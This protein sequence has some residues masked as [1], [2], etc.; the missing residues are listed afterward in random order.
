MTIEC[1]L[2]VN[3]SVTYHLWFYLVRESVVSHVTICTPDHT[4]LKAVL[5]FQVTCFLAKHKQVPKLSLSLSLDAAKLPKC[6]F[7]SFSRPQRTNELILHWSAPSASLLQRHCSV[8]CH[9]HLYFDSA[10]FHWQDIL[11]LFSCFSHIADFPPLAFSHLFS[12]LFCCSLTPSPLLVL[13]T[14]H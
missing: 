8:H 14:Q 12:A 2:S 9:C 13:S 6:S 10:L 3:V 11:R 1:S 7:A 5:C 4:V